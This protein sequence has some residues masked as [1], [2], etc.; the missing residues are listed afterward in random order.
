MDEGAEKALCTR[1]SLLAVGVGKV[2]GKFL[3]GE[4]V[5]LVNLRE[6]IIGVAKVRLSAEEL[7]ERVS[8]KGSI[9][10]HADDIVL[11]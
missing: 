10:A 6:T 9:A 1:K 5:Q 4:V 3:P 2:K 8:K 7:K 11:F